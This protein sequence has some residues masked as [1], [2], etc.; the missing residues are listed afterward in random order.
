MK[1][2]LYV[3]LCLNAFVVGAQTTSGSESTP[4]AERSGAAMVGRISGVLADSATAK[5][6]PFATVALQSIDGKLITGATTDDKGA[7]MLEKIAVGSYRLAIS[8]V[9]YRTRV[10][11]K[12]VISAEK[13]ELELGRIVV[14]AD[15][16]NLKEVEVVG[17]K[18]LIEDK[19][20]RLVYNAEKDISNA[21]GTA[22]D[23]LRKVPMLTV[24]FNGNVQMRGNSNIK[25]L[26]NGKPSSIM[27]RNL[28]DALKQMP[29]NI[30]KSVE[31]ITSPGAKYD[32]EG[33]GGV[34]NIITKKALQGANG[35]VNA[36]VGNFNRGVGTSLNLKKKKVG[37]SLSTNV[38]QYRNIQQNQSTRTALVDGAPAS[39]LTQRTS[40]DNT[41]LG[42]Y[43]EMSFDYDPDSTS[44]INF[45][46]NV[47]GGNFPNNSTVINRLTKPD[48]EELQAFRNETRFRNPYGNGQLDL[49]YT[50]TFRKSGVESPEQ[51][52]SFL[53]QYSRMP[54]NY[55]Y[56]T[57][58]YAMSEVVTYRERSTNY[59]R[60]NEFTFQSDYTHPLK[61]NGRKDT[62]SLKLEVGAKAILRYIGSEFRVERSDDGGPGFTPAPELSND[63]TYTQKVY[64]TYA[65]L[66]LDTKRKWGLNA[67]ARLE[68]TDIQG[69]FVTTQTAFT[70]N[71]NNLIPSI[72]L[73]KG[74]KTHTVKVSYTQRISRPLI[75]YLNPWV[76]AADPKNL[77]TGNPF[78]SPELSHNTELSHSIT[79]KKGVSINSSLYWRQTNNA[80]EYLSTVNAE[81]VSTTK[82]Q[83][84]GQRAN[85]GLS[86]NGSGQP[87]KDWNLSGGIDLRYVD[88]TSPALNLRNSGWIWNV[89]MNTSYKLPKNYTIQVNGNYGSGWINLQGNYSGWYWYGI[90]AKREIWDK[91]ASLTLGMNSP[92]NRGVRQTGRQIAPSFTSEF[93]ALNVTRAVR[94][95]FE[96]RFGQ[97][98]SGGGKQ[99]KKINNDDRSR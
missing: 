12:V 64:S 66:R 96:W 43:G 24:D 75:W 40:M 36:T 59:S 80:I 31:V 42:G 51:E 65:S 32:A 61:F 44:R 94:L 95:T 18:T 63:F 35:T 37:L 52:F 90:S 23:V 3:M 9:G 99:T 87:N 62:T 53:T 84:I 39:I 29:A 89:N 5:P 28:A 41:G 27:A 10:V 47:W 74:I 17:Q 91:K 26:V 93:N 73:S 34:I 48:G 4:P 85:Y 2:L 55:F 30:I 33:A 82:P 8:F 60:N 7:F 69:D 20:D 21:G 11:D 14:S 88:F 98:S 46:A 58:R 45:A 97:M 25:V 68:R 22:V 54:D 77:T 79:T 15:S 13:P 49:G 92:F 78:L 38:Y 86:L 70:S 67:G 56:D 81:G 71:Y 57:D 16:R 6:V 72:T 19:G 76:N 50:K 1:F 83:N